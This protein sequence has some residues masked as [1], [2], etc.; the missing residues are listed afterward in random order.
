MRPYNNLDELMHQAE[1]FIDAVSTD[2]FTGGNHYAREFVRQYF[3][4]NGNPIS[5]GLVGEVNESIY[6]FNQSRN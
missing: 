6:A 2:V 4:A 1:Y 5:N 3:D